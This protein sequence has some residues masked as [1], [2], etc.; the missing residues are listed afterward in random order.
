MEKYA[1]KYHLSELIRHI[2]LI[3]VKKDQRRREHLTLIKILREKRGR[4][5][6]LVEALRPKDWYMLQ[7]YVSRIVDAESSSDVDREAKW[8]KWAIRRMRKN[9]E[10]NDL[11]AGEG[12]LVQFFE[13]FRHYLLKHASAI[14][15]HVERGNDLTPP[16][17]LLSKLGRPSVELLRAECLH[18]IRNDIV[19]NMGI[20]RRPTVE[21][22]VKVGFKGKPPRAVKGKRLILSLDH[23]VEILNANLATLDLVLGIDEPVYLEHFNEM[24]K[25]PESVLRL[26]PKRGL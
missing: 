23:F 3:A 25:R 10:F 7:G 24:Q 2:G 6:E 21:S 5:N 16:E 11:I 12:I 15:V 13:V 26:A 22:T 19:H 4:A 18:F 14:G 9:Y 20:A 17:E 1:V 8:T